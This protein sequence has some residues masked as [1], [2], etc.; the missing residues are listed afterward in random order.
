MDD[1]RGAQRPPLTPDGARGGASLRLRQIPILG[2][3]RRLALRVRVLDD[4]RLLMPLWFPVT[5]ERNGVAQR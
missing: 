5:A 3:L 2:Q 4:Q 1:K